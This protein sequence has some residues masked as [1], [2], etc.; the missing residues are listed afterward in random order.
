MLGTADP[1]PTREHQLPR[2]S[3]PSDS[4]AAV[5]A[6]DIQPLPSAPASFTASPASSKSQSRHHEIINGAGGGGGNVILQWGHNKRTRAPR[7][8]CRASGDAASAHSRQMLKIPRRSTAGM[9]PPPSGGSYA[10]GANLRT[11]VAVR[12]A[13]APL[14][15]GGPTRSEKRSPSS[16]PEKAQK[17]PPTNGAVD[18]H[19]NPQ[20]SKLV[21]S[22]QDTG[23]SGSTPPLLAIGERLNLDQFEWPKI[24]IS[25]SRKEKEDDFLA[26]KGTKLPQRPKKRAKNI[27]KNLQ[28]AQSCIALSLRDKIPTQFWDLEISVG[29]VDTQDDKY[30]FGRVFAEYEYFAK[31]CSTI[32]MWFPPPSFPTTL[33]QPKT[34]HVTSIATGRIKPWVGALLSS[35]TWGSHASDRRLETSGSTIRAVLAYQESPLSGGR[36]CRPVGPLSTFNV[37]RTAARTTGRF[38]ELGHHARRLRPARTTGRFRELGHH[39][40]R[41][42]PAIP[43]PPTLARSD[44]FFR[45]RCNLLP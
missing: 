13:A 30:F 16:L 29:E 45:N 4:P 6:S 27:D 40:R 22:D 14:R 5:A 44:P 39:A 31:L 1:S 11:S 9:A 32:M 23:G 25:L 20:E 10:R 7:A 12:D 28:N 33:L 37:G 17:N 8:E 18:G 38:R 26:M 21:A 43:K 42:R 35:P 15:S 36:N 19:M 41:L 24:C 3:F 34:V 2:I